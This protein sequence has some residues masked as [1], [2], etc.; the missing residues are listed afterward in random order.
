M[1]GRAY[2][3]WRVTLE[4]AKMKSF[5]LPQ[6][7]WRRV[8]VACQDDEEQRV[9]GNYATLARTDPEYPPTQLLKQ[10]KTRLKIH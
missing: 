2:L 4:K 10:T 8:P 5:K 9:P 1:Y 3:T 6:V 7:S